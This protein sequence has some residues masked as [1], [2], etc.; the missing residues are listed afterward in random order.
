MDIIESSIRYNLN[1]LDG[2]I[3]LD[4]GSTDNTLTILKNLKEEGLPVFYFEDV[5][6]KFEQDKKMTQLLKMAVD[7][8]NADIIVTLDADEFITSNNLGNP[9]KILEKLE[10]P[11]YYL[12][13]WK[14]YIPDF[15]ENIHNKFIPSQITYVRDEKLETFYKVIIPKELVKEYNVKISFGNHDLIYDQE[16]GNLIN[17]VYKSDLC[18]SHFPIRSKEQT[19]SKIVVGWI[20]LPLEIRMGHFKGSMFHWYKIFEWIKEFGEIKDEDVIKFAKL[21]ALENKDIKVNVHEDAMDLSFCRNIEIKYTNEKVRPISNILEQFEITYKESLEQKQLLLN[22]IEDLSVELD[23][24][25]NLKSNK[26]KQLNNKLKNY[27]NS[28]SWI[29]TSPF[30]KISIII[31]NILN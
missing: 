28:K 29:I 16:Y 20:N 19:L 10:S 18:I 27:E 1:I 22:K 7:E 8:F 31:R 30:R 4:N 21:F 3:I 24:L 17:N 23:E 13:K 12:V 14:I 2:M 5:D 15:R 11:N 6:S 25:Y 9:R 26:E